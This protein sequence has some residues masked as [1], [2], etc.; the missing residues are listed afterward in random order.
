MQKLVRLIVGAGLALCAAMP[1]FADITGVVNDADLGVPAVGAVVNAVDATDHAIYSAT[2]DAGGTYTITIPAASQS[3]NF[4]V[5]VGSYSTMESFVISDMS[6]TPFH[7]VSGT[8]SGNDFY[9]TSTGYGIELSGSTGQANA[10]IKIHIVQVYG[11]TIEFYIPTD[12]SGNYDYNCLTESYSLAGNDSYTMTAEKTGYSFTP[13]YNFSP[14]RGS[15]QNIVNNF[16][17]TAL[18]VPVITQV[19]PQVG[20]NY[21]SLSGMIIGANFASGAAVKLT[22]TG[23]SDITAAAATVASS[24][25]ITF[26]LPLTGAAAGLWNV[27]VTNSDTGTNTLA[28]GLVVANALQ[29]TRWKPFTPMNQA[30]YMFPLLR[31]QNGSL[32]APGGFVTSTAGTAITEL[33]SL[34]SDSWTYTGSMVNS[35][36]NHAAA[37]MADG[38]VLAAGGYIGAVGTN[39]AE[40]YNT[41]TG[42]WA[43]TGNMNKI[44]QNFPL[45]LLPSGKILAA[46]GKNSSVIANA[47]LYD[48]SAGTWTA[49]GS[50]AHAR[51]MHTATLLPDGTVLAAGGY[52]DTAG[53]TS[54]QTAEIFN[55]SSW[56]DTTGTMNAARGEHT[57]TLLLNGKVLVAGGI[58]NGTYLSSAEIYDPSTGLWTATGSMSTARAKHTAQLLPD[59]TVM[60]TGGASAATTALASSEIYDPSDGTWSAALSMP[61]AKL[62]LSS[63]YL[64]NGRIMAVGGYNGTGTLYT[65]T[66]LYGYA[67]YS[68]GGTVTATGSGSAISG[69]T[70]SVT[71]SSTT[72]T[73]TDA[74]GN[75]IVPLYSDGTYQITPTKAFYTFNPVSSTTVALAGNVTS[76]YTGTVATFTVSGTLQAYGSPLAN[77]T[78]AV[79]GSATTSTLT[80]ASGHYSFTLDGGGSYTLTPSATNYW[81]TPATASTTTL[82]ANWTNDFTAAFT[83]YTVSGTI[84]IGT[85]TLAGVTIAI[86]GSST[87]STTSDA[88][89]N[90]TINLPVGGNYTL[91]PSKAYYS[92]APVSVSTAAL[93][94]PWSGNNFTATVDTYTVSGT[95]TSGGNALAGVTVSVTGSST[96][97]TV[98][99][100]SGNYS[101]TLDALGAYT[102]TPAKTHY[103]F[104]PT[105]AT[106]SSLTADSTQNFTAVLSSY[107]V[108]GYVY[109]AGAPLLGA[110]VSLTGDRTLNTTTDDT[111][112]Y[113][114][115]VSAEGSYTVTPDKTNYH[116]TPVSASTASLNMT[117]VTNFTAHMTTYTVSGTVTLGGSPMA[118]VQVNVTGSAST[119]L[120]TD[121][122]GNYTVDLEQGGS[123]TLTPYKANYW[124]APVSV[125]TASLQGTWSANNFA[126]ALSTYTVNGTITQG[127]H[128]FAGVTV[129]VTG[130]STTST[131][132]DALGNYS[133]ILDGN[134]D[135]T[136]T[137]SYANYWFTPAA[138]STATLSGAWSNNF[139]ATLS[140]YTVSG[141]VSAGGSP[142]AGVT[143]SVSGDSTGTAVTDASG[144]YSFILAGNGDYTLTPSKANYWFAPSAVSTTTLSGAWTGNDF[145]ATAS[146]YTVSGTV[147]L[148]GNAMS[149][150]TVSVTGS[151]SSSTVTDASGNYSFILAGDGNYTLT[152][153]KRN[154]WFAPGSV[155][156]TTLSGSWTG[157]NFS[158]TLST[159][160]ASGTI[161]QGAHALAGVTVTLSGDSTASTVTDASGN[162]SFTL[163][164]DGDYTVTPSKTN[165]WFAP[166]AV[167]TTT[168]SGA[169]SN[170]FTATLS[171]YTIRGTV[172]VGGGYLSGATISITGDAS[173]S[174]VT[175]SHGY[176]SFVMG[177]SGAYTITP[178]KTNYTFS[179]VSLST[180]SLN[181]NWTTADFTA[182][183]D[184]F[185]LSGTV[186][187]NGSA[188][189]G[190]SVSITGDVTTTV[191][192][193]STGTYRVTLYAG[194]NYGITPTKA[195][196]EFT[197]SS[198]TITNMSGNANGDFTG[199]LVAFTISGRIASGASGVAGVT[200]T[201]SGSTTTSTTTDALGNYTLALTAGNYVL[202]P[203]LTSY[204]MTPMAQA[205]TVTGNASGNDFAAASTGGKDIVAVGGPGGYAEPG[206]GYPARIKLASP[207]ASGHVT[208]KIYTLRGARLVRSYE[209]DVI[210]GTPSELIWDC[211]NT[212]SQT[213]G[214]G[215]YIAVVDG[216]GYDNV[217]IKIGVLR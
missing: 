205:I 90:Y 151:V 155:S 43:A 40:V 147:T 145:A 182:I 179:P 129:S 2:A 211:L 79:S 131:T 213:V 37:V 157:N 89:G 138:V 110:T 144:N 51:H 65:T 66:S 153:S 5:T 99:D 15:F 215:V 128:A 8:S 214:S 122:S 173:S 206:R 193:G 3:H 107:T 140:T 58:S 150:V 47:D 52:S 6:G 11:T 54:I 97:S 143:V 141:T 72:T 123:Y 80:D 118:G 190:V 113:S 12:S 198:L 192:T 204:V 75:Y 81:F 127:A 55:G 86:T 209:T 197:P 88:S 27:V 168:L 74:S 158:A 36:K 67:L 201:V 13:T 22:R 112:Y 212:D 137:P 187:E 101:F 93:I 114:F 21:E 146:T 70:M 83:T 172:S 44:R 73:T 216:A 167:S 78:V 91:T 19:L 161:T 152:P 162:Y 41:S 115:M 10:V 119:V 62:G 109:Y 126:A 184:T 71:G 92:F 154:Y 120:T 35:R 108:A 125:T 203:T 94:G 116:F 1:A 7:Y 30:R 38:N 111:G 156:T 64:P 24:S 134:G 76:N 31:L 202:T 32:L 49:T 176:Y 191:V 87:T 16:S 96:T 185:T 163:D 25:K 217:K 159:Y 23:Y 199:V 207:P 57:A 186:T 63:A 170:D 164:G 48:P 175:D 85:G 136:I 29:G 60:V 188:L 14:A 56:S 124:F 84:N 4:Y 104:T 18:A 166:G 46:A 160:T 59:G 200:V 133:F 142:L 139:D 50:L 61:S 98:T 26:T 183:P 210:A 194:G 53:A 196:Y 100:A 45:L 189:A 121:A 33:Y 148:G 82:T 208:V 180:A 174:T 103:G 132:T 181:T 105:N 102:L 39:T 68:I 195:N 42:Q 9:G 77:A 178:A 149:G 17:G 69:V 117:W 106:I 28:G 34:T 169:W 135:Y 177:G 165:Y 130:S 171:T 20:Y 95:I